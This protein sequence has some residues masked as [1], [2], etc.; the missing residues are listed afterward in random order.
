[1]NLIIFG[2]PGAGKGTQSNQIVND[3]NLKQV[4]T[5]DLLRK[6]TKLQTK[7]GKKI[8]SKLNNGELVPDEVV[9]ILIEKFISD[10]NNSEG[11]GGIA[12]LYITSKLFIPEKEIIFF[13]F[14]SVPLK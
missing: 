5:G 3:F 13:I 6:E 14:S 8:E 4:S 11:L 1:M 10:P 12:P 2:P 9:N 7:L